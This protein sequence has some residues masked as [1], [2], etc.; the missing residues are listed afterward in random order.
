MTSKKPKRP[1]IITLTVRRIRR[2]ARWF[3][4]DEKPVSAVML[5]RWAAELDAYDAR[6][7]RKDSRLRRRK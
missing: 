2:A 3:D 5:R 6:E 4:D 7:T 1:R